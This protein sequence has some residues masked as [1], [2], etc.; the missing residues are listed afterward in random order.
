VSI[1]PNQQTNQGGQLPPHTCSHVQIPKHQLVL[2]EEGDEVLP[3]IT[4]DSFATWHTPGSTIFKVSPRGAP[5]PLM[6]TGDAL[7]AGG[8]G[9][10]AP[11]L[12]SG[13]DEDAEAGPAAKYALLDRYVEDKV[14]LHGFHAPFPALFSLAPDGLSYRGVHVPWLWKA[15]IGLKCKK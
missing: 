3:G 1:G 11:W 7:P 13:F 12:R 8:A 15:G 5:A 6:V 14:I 10:E 4:A 2:F 9:L